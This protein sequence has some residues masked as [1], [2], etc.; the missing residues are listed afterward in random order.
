[1]YNSGHLQYDGAVHARMPQHTSRF[2][3][4]MPP[5]NEEPVN[6]GSNCSPWLEPAFLPH[7]HGS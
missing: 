5:W 6:G 3:W 1:M 7:Q 2:W 4:A